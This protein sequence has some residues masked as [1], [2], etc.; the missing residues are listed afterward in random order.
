MSSV[1]MGWGI[2]PDV[3]AADEVGPLVQFMRDDLDGKVDL[4][5]LK[6]LFMSIEP[7]FLVG[8]EDKVNLLIDG[9]IP[10]EKIVH[11]LNNV[12]LT[13]ALSLKPF[14]EIERLVMGLI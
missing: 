6:H 2:V 9:G 5:Q 7:R 13:K 14:E 8:F 3:H 11:V 12:N 1:N 4:T 10:R